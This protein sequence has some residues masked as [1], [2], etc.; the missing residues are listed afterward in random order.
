[1]IRGRI[2]SVTIST[3]LC[4]VLTFL[5]LSALCED[6]PSSA[7]RAMGY[8]PLGLWEALKSLALVTLL[9]AGPLYEVL[10]VDGLWRDWMT[11]QPLCSVWNE[12]TSWRNLVMVS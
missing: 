1:M 5:L 4:S 7:L 3:T 8:W 12:W 11:L 2:T 6:G 10:V 9:F